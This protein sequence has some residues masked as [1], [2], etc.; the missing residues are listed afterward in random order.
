MIATGTTVNLAIEVLKEHG[1]DEANIILLCLFSTQS[2]K[3][4]ADI[5]F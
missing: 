3:T 2:G 1:V 5:I 4:F